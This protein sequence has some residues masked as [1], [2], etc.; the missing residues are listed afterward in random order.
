[1]T[2]KKAMGKANSVAVSP[3]IHA[4][5]YSIFSFRLIKKRL[6]ESKT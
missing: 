3:W 6:M 2:A 1:M 5:F 4:Y